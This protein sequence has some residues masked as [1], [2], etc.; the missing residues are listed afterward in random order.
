MPSDISGR[1]SKWPWLAQEEKTENL[2]YLEYF[3]PPKMG[4][5]EPQLPGFSFTPPH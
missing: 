5:K 1:K 4:P 3:W 2:K